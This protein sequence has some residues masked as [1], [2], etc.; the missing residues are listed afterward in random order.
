MHRRSLSLAVPGKMFYICSN[1]TARRGHVRA[2]RLDR[3]DRPK[4]RVLRDI[5][6]DGTVMAEMAEIC[7]CDGVMDRITFVLRGRKKG[8]N[9]QLGSERA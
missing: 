5:T 7:G 4:R 1:H 2:L 3:D 6:C 8:R 9:L